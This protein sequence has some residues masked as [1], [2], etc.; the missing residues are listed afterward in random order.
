MVRKGDTVML[1]QTSWVDLRSR[2]TGVAP[3][4]GC[5]LLDKPLQ[6][7]TITFALLTPT[8]PLLPPRSPHISSYGVT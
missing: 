6:S 1:A 3:G 8:P 4:T 2:G 5:S 7:R